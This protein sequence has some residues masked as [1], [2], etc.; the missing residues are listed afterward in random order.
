MAQDLGADEVL[1]YRTERFEQKYRDARFD[2]ILDVIGGACLPD[3][4]QATSPKHASIRPITSHF[5]L[6]WPCMVLLC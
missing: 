2:V 6:Q 4:L 5:R 3:T 1:D